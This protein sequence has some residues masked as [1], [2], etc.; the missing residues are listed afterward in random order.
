MDAKAQGT[1]A[2]HA[3]ASTVMYVCTCFTIFRPDGQECHVNQNLLGGLPALA[4]AV[5][6]LWLVFMA[7]HAGANH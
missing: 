2:R 5:Q 6:H 1:Y 4:I 3:Y 7:A